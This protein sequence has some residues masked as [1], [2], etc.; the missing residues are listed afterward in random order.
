MQREATG[1]DVQRRQRSQDLDGLNKD[2]ASRW[3][4]DV[5]AS[6]FE[7]FSGLGPVD[8]GFGAAKVGVK[9]RLR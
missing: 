6:Y 1:R 2:L 3:E 8:V 9:Y 4:L 7:L 5:G